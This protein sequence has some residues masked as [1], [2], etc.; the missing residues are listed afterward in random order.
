M[1]TLTKVVMIAGLAFG[2]ATAAQASTEFVAADNAVTS[3]ICVA[4]AKGKKI[5]L[6]E[7]IKDSGL[8]RGFV[9][10]NVTC[11]EMPIVEFVELYGENVAKINGYITA[12]EYTGSL[13]SRAN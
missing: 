8:T 6:H 1:K 2:A 4:A 10:K 9:E 5:K 11:N 7:A 13:I 3:D 12:N